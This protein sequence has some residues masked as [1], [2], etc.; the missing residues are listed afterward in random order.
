MWGKRAKAQRSVA[1]PCSSTLSRCVQRVGYKK[2]GGDVHVW[3]RSSG[4][5]AQ[6]ELKHGLKQLPV[7]RNRE[8]GRLREVA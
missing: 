5:I 8:V 2:L 3:L 7:I 6:G 4:R 1:E